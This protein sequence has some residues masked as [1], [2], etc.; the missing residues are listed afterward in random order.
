MADHRS[1][2]QL[3]SY[4][5]C[6]HAY[7]LERIVRVWTKPAAWFPM[8]TAV[9]KAVEE[10]ELSGREM[11]LEEAQEIFRD[12]YVEET[13][14]YLSD[15]PQAIYWQSSGPYNGPQDIIRRMRKGKEHIEGYIN[16]Y[17]D[18]KHKHLVP[19]VTDDGKMAIELEFEI[20]LDG[21]MVKGAIDSVKQDLER[22]FPREHLIV[23]DVKSGANPGNI[24]QPELYKIA[25][26]EMYPTATVKWGQF[27]MTAKGKPFPLRAGPY[28]LTEVT[29]SDIVE[30]FQ[31][32]DSNIKAG[33]FPAKPE[34]DK[35]R[36]C[37]VASSCKFKEI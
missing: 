30:K 27:F 17:T 9:H 4:E 6:P 10:W 18:E 2:S 28:D 16:W 32:L 3:S 14:R 5:Q 31:R 29:R 13:N 37:P 7:Y 21:V 8:G 23:E 34:P 12:T 15:T 1:W 26:E 24:G 25:V 36:R 35:C 20:D 22:F 19:W 33:D 11:S